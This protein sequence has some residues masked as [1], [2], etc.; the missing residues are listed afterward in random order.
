MAWWDDIIDDENND[1]RVKRPA[2]IK[3]RMSV[4]SK[5]KLPTVHRMSPVERAAFSAEIAHLR[6]EWFRLVF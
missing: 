3:A 5:T 4:L 6:E 1:W 2:E